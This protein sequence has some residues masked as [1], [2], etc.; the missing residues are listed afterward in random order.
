MYHRNYRAK[1]LGWGEDAGASNIN[2]EIIN[3]CSDFGFKEVMKKAPDFLV[4]FLNVIL[5]LEESDRIVS[6]AVVNSDLPSTSMYGSHLTCDL[7]CVTDCK[8]RK[9]L[10]EIQNKFTS[11]Y[12]DKALIELSRVISNWDHAAIESHA[13]SSGGSNKKPKLYVGST[14]ADAKEF[15]NGISG[16][17]VI[18]ITNHN[19]A[20]GDKANLSS[21]EEVDHAQAEPNI[22]NSYRMMLDRKK[23][24]QGKK[25]YLRNIDSRVIIVNLARFEKSSASELDGT[26][27]DGYLFA[28]KLD[29]NGCSPASEPPLNPYKAVND[30]EKAYSGGDMGLTAFYKQLNKATRT[31]EELGFFEKRLLEERALLAAVAAEAAADAVSEYVKAHFVQCGRP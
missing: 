5:E 17:V 24:E 3:P 31:P 27:L 13:G 15:W 14:H 29:R 26:P 22:I 28:F 20:A 6:V 10:C 18:V 9:Y 1:M 2:M 23:G 25:R 7:L 30:L 16:A 12:P 21:S 19:L 4:G 8:S 11:Q